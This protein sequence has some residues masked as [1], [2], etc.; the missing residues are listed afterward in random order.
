MK[1]YLWLSFLS[2]LAVTLIACNNATPTPFPTETA[3]EPTN[4]AEPEADVEETA[5]EPTLGTAVVDS[6]TVDLANNSVTV[7]GNLPDGCTTIHESAQT[8]DGNTIRIELSTTRPADTVCTDALVP[9]TEEIPIDTS[10]LGDGSYSVEVNG[11]TGDQPIVVGAAPAAITQA[12]IINIAWQWADLMEVEPAS[13]SAVP[14][15]EN[16]TLTFFADLTLSIKADCNNVAGSYTL[17]GNLLTIQ[18]GPSTMAFCGENSLDQQY[19]ALLAQVSKVEGGNGRLFLTTAADARM[20]FND[21]GAVETPVTETD[22]SEVVT[23]VEATKIIHPG[24]VSIDTQGLPYPYQV[25]Y[26]E[27]TPYQQE[28][29]PGPSGLPAHIQINFGNTSE[30]QQGDPIIYI[31]PVAAYQ[32]MW[33]AH[34]NESVSNTLA[35]IAQQTYL[36]PQPAPT[37]GMTALPGEELIGTNDVA[38]QVGRAATIDQQQDDEIASKSGYR[39]VGRWDQSP[40]PITNQ[41]LRYVYQGFTNDGEYLVAMFW[42][43]RTDQLVDDVSGLSEEEMTA[44]NNDPIAAIEAQKETLNGLSASDWEPDLATLD[45]MIRSLKIADMAASGL[46]NKTWE[47]TGEGSNFASDGPTTADL[48]G[49]TYAITFNADGSYTAIVDCNNGSGSFAVKGGIYGEVAFQPGPSTLA[50]CGETSA[51]DSINNLISSAESFTVSPSGNTM[52]LMMPN[53]TGNYTFKANPTNFAAVTEAPAPITRAYGKTWQWTQFNDP[54]NGEQAIAEP[55]RYQLVLNEDGTVNVKADCNQVSGTYTTEGNSISIILGPSTAAACADDSLADQ[56]MQHLS[57]A[58]TIFFQDESM[59]FDTMADSGTMKFD[60]A[61][62]STAEAEN[63]GILDTV[64]QWTNF[65][66]PASGPQEIND[67]SRYQMQLATDGTIQIQ[68]D[69]NNGSGSYSVDGQSITIVL[70]PMTRAACPDDSVADDFINNL[71]AAALWFTQDG[72]L[73]FDLKFDSGT[74]RFAAADGSADSDDNTATNEETAESLQ[75]ETVNI[76]LQGLAQSF[77]WEVQSDVS[78][79]ILV[80]FDGEDPA[81]VLANNGRRVY[82]FPIEN[83]QSI[84]GDD[85][86]AQVQQLELLI[87]SGVGQDPM[88]VLP[89]P[90]SYMDRWAQY[91]NLDF[92]QGPGVRYISDSPHRQA[93][94]VWSNGTTHYYYQGLTQDGRFYISLHWPVSTD[95]LPDTAE[96]APEDVKATATNS[97]TY[98]EYKATLIEELNALTGDDFDPRLSRLDALVASLH[99]QN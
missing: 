1:K 81:D 18:T 90:S 94:G 89:P 4:T 46:V 41:N 78:P 53:G 38:T 32:A 97:E 70:G 54:A 2:L 5:P 30:R 44:F 71:G 77:E 14:M 42:P 16:Y 98:E 61:S 20:G 28:Q 92:T 25:N 57:V 13:Q 9:Y 68:A 87:E 99:L 67:P 35:K 48:H 39:F 74:M 23:E 21:G 64:W 63:E 3:P 93:I 50:E 76:S 58:T 11:F 37:S 7:M 6:V 12:D 60:E 72:D 88:P 8:V 10:N 24:Q 79:H 27:A 34:G 83:Y 96:S 56:Y 91:Q 84:G 47:W 31:I 49:A 80:T 86:V 55:E 26:V 95:T 15:P 75:E 59:Y 73:F 52:Y 62:G 36:L 17:E 19:L 85:V 40:N 43:V 69:C 22:T 65:T 51:S 29:A 45:A 33:E 82:I 66:D